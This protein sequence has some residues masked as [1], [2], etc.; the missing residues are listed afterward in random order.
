[1]VLIK[2]SDKYIHWN[3]FIAIDTDTEKLARY[4]EF[5]SDNFT[6]YSIEMAHLLL[7]AASEVDVVAKIL[8]KRHGS[9]SKAKKA[10]KIHEYRKVLK[11]ALPNIQRM[12]IV[13]PRYGLSLQPWEQWGSNENPNW[14]T[15]YNKVKH[16]RS[17]DFHRANLLYA[18]NA[19]AGLF[20]MLLYLY[21]KEAEAGNLLPSPSLF[22]VDT[23]FF[24]GVDL[25]SGDVRFIYSL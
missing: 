3:Y 1:M 7:T 11:R 10:K 22:R 4:I 15:A 6:T 21:K 12:N 19:V 14:W 16:H 13:I 24:N 17:T 5:S 9:S 23:E 18:L 25:S 20:V 2:D 8:C